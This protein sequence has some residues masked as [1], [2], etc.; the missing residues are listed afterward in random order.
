MCEALHTS[1]DGY[2]RKGCRFTIAAFAL[3][4][5]FADPHLSLALYSVENALAVTT[6]LLAGVI[7]DHYNERERH[8]RHAREWWRK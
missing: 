3:M 7:A 2:G 4:D 1:P 6:F 5:P 8:V